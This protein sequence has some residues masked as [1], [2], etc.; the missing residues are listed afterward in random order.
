[1][2]AAAKIVILAIIQGVAEFLPISSS[3]HLVLFGKMLGLGADEG[4]IRLTITLHA[5]TLAAIIVFYFRRLLDMVIIPAR[6]R[7]IPL[8]I[9][10][11]V[12]AAVV[13]VSLKKTGVIDGFF[14]NLVLVAMGFFC[15]GYLLLRSD[16]R[17]EKTV[18]LERM[19]YPRSLLIG[20]AQAFAI[21][22]GVSRSGSTISTAVRNGLEKDDAAAF[23]FFLACPAIGGAA[24]LEAL[25]LLKDGGG[26]AACSPS[27]LALGFAVSAGVGYLSLKLLIGILKRGKLYWFAFYC[28]GI[29]LVALSVHFT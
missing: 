9:V 12:P 4:M 19:G 23:S 8:L 10:G 7:L 25:S 13:G 5:G 21:L 17:V 20:I 28:F 18:A 15:T 24:L 2:P 11:S 3:G 6:R 16:V 29:G 26:T 22:P 14:D 27:M 1:M